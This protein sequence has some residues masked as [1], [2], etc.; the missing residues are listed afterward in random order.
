MSEVSQKH[1]IAIYAGTF[2][3]V[4]YGH[5]DVLERA[6]LLFDKVIISVSASSSKK[7]IFTVEERLEMISDCVKNIPNVKV[8]SFTGLLVEYAKRS[9]ATAIVRGLRAISDFEYE[10]Q[11]ALTNRKIAENITTVFLMPNEKYTYLNSTL[12]REIASL[13]G[14]VSP[15]VPCNVLEKLNE[16][17]G[18]SS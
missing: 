3:P 7:T 6:S 17:Y 14:D 12:V 13:G 9:N 11:M 5:I 18:K 15:F 10:F 4:T 16:K 1:K 2:D 8:E